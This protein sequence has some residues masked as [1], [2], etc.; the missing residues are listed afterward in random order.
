VTPNASSKDVSGACS[1]FFNKTAPANSPKE[2][3]EGGVPPVRDREEGRNQEPKSK[4]R[5]DPAKGQLLSKEGNEERGKPNSD[6][7]RLQNNSKCPLALQKRQRKAEE[8]EPDKSSLP[9]PS[10]GLKG[11]LR[12]MG[13]HCNLR[14]QGHPTVEF[15]IDFEFEKE[16]SS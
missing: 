9:S 10:P 15:E 14:D 3:K 12:R 4:R 13:R 11:P 16:Q 5:G 6:F 2:A 7:L 8:T 1:D